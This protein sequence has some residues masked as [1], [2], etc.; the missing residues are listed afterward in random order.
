MF[1]IEEIQPT[2]MNIA[3]LAIRMINDV[4]AVLLPL[5]GISFGTIYIL[6]STPHMVYHCV[7][8]II[9]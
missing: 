8:I 2:D 6:S 1:T 4:F 7:V 3:I 9:L 5:I